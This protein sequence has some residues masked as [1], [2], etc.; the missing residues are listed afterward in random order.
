V[1]PGWK[2]AIGGLLIAGLTTYMGYLGASAS[3]Q[4]YLTVDECAAGDSSLAGQRVRVSGR[5]APGTLRIAA[6]R[7]QADFSLQ[8]ASAK[9]TVICSGTLP[10]NLVE[11][12]EVVV[13]G[14]LDDSGTLR[15][16]KLLTRC[17]SKYA[18]KAPPAPSR[19][20]G[21][22]IRPTSGSPSIGRGDP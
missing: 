6:D 19:W 1:S 15:G 14:R 10:A 18:A 9:L 7:R 4:Y 3:W 12:I 13:E 11:D 20:D 8:G 5:V 16:N 17:A 2:L 22:Q 21:L